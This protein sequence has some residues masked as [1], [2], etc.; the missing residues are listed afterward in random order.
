MKITGSMIGQAGWVLADLINMFRDEEQQA[1]YARNKKVNAGIAS[2]GLTIGGKLNPEGAA[3]KAGPA[4]EKKIPV[5]GKEAPQVQEAF[6]AHNAWIEQQKPGKGP[7]GFTQGPDG[8]ITTTP[9]QA[10]PIQATGAAGS[11]KN[12]NGQTPMT[13]QQQEQ[14]MQAEQTRFWTPER[15]Q[16]NQDLGP[17]NELAIRKKRKPDNYFLSIAG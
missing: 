10:L 14:Q 13:K 6:K 3:A 12:L 9:Q 5:T 11:Q 16:T 2:V 17:P 15:T 1:Q 4:T 8:K 7:G